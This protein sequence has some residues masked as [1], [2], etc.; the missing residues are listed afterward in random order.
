M[1]ELPGGAFLKGL[2]TGSTL[3]SRM[4][5][6]K[7]KREAMAQAWQ[8]HLDQLKMQKA[9]AGRAAQAAEDAHKLAL[10]KLDPLSAFKQMVA[11]QQQMNG[12]QGGMQPSQEQSSMPSIGGMFGQ[13]PQEMMEP[14][15][16]QFPLAEQQGLQ[17]IM[18]EPE[19]GQFPA[20]QQKIL[21]PMQQPQAD[22]PA[23]NEQA[24]NPLEAANASSATNGLDMEKIK[25][26]PLLRAAFKQLFKYDPI[27]KPSS[28][29]GAA[30]EGLDMARLKK[31]YGV[32]SEAYRNAQAIQQSKETQ[33]K[34]LSDK[35]SR[36][37]H[38]LKPGDVAIHDSET[39]EE[40]GFSKQ[41]TKDQQ[42]QEEN[43]VKFDEIY[44][45]VFNGASVFSG[46]GATLKLEQAARE[47]KI[48]PKARKL[49][50]DFLIAEKALTNTTVTEAAR[51]GS[52]KQ[53]QVFNRYRESLQAEDVPKKLK[54]WIKEYGIPA[55]ANL[56]AGQRW[57][58]I[59]DEVDNK[60]K[61]LVPARR[62]YYYDPEKQYAH[63]EEMHRG[64]K[65]AE[66]TYHDNELV[67]VE[68]PNGIEVMTYA[69]AKRKGAA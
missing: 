28:Y 33:R 5:G 10:M 50:D 45:L 40:I 68:G 39:G 47:Y 16:G 63:D 38:G 54:K 23:L 61:R 67:Q 53:N 3:Y 25:K 31:D 21:N 24:I 49:I 14:E 64:Q 46:P 65:S 17:E 69:E 8:Q 26:D 41:L 62:N 55:E 43:R 51:F 2:D 29:T 30:R 52:G 27:E 6:P 7:L 34:D 35:R 58:K 4:M 44:P 1:P 59:L 60:A 9:A 20:L 37:L 11:Y 66:E 56:K 36:E 13:Q 15:Q 18:P 57:Q 32:N 12:G 48:N 19:Q 22:V 42:M